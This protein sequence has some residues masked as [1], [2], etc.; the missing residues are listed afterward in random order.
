MDINTDFLEMQCELLNSNELNI[1]LFDK[2]ISHTAFKT[3]MLHEGMLKRNTTIESIKSEFKSLIEKES[4]EFSLK[5]DKYKKV[6]KDLMDISNEIINDKDAY[7]SKIIE[8]ISKYT[9]CTI[10]DETTIYLYALGNDGGFCL[11][12]GELFINLLRSKDD[13]IN[14]LSHELY[15]GRE[16]ET[17]EE[18]KL[19]VKY[20]S[21]N[22]EN[23]EN[24]ELLL[25]QFAEEGIATLIQ[26][27]G[28]YDV[29]LGEVKVSL[30]E[31][32]S[33]NSLTLDERKTLLNKYISGEMRYKVAYS[34][35]NEVYKKGGLQAIESWSKEAKLTLFHKALSDLIKN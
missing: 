15:H 22:V 33:W 19:R 6:Q 32:N 23:D 10:P 21:L 1:D 31:I 4:N 3:F 24:G 7:I 27:D 34:L 35:A 12:G 18:F 11:Q 8:R 13:L 30:E 25:S 2:F 29:S 16:I 26:Y 5:L 20:N 9:K 17:E 14:I 28:N